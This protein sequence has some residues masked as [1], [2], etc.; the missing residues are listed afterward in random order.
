M[1]LGVYSNTFLRGFLISYFAAS[2]KL[3]VRY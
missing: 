2:P 3:H 1:I